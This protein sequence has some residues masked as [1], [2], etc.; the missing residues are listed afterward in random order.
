MTWVPL[1]DRGACVTTADYL[2]GERLVL[3]RLSAEGAGFFVALVGEE[4][5][6]LEAL[7]APRNE[8]GT[9]FVP[10]APAAGAG[11]DASLYT[12]PPSWAS[13]ADAAVMYWEQRAGVSIRA[14][15]EAHHRLIQRLKEASPVLPLDSLYA[16]HASLLHAHLPDLFPLDPIYQD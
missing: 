11:Q 2:P 8:T 5:R 16:P 10:Q 1:H 7:L 6:A 4:V 14:V 12:P 15:P 13:L 3:R 9:T